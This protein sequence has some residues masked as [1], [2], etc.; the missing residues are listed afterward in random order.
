MSI[1]QERIRWKHWTFIVNETGRKNETERNRTKIKSTAMKRVFCEWTVRSRAQN[2]DWLRKSYT[3]AF[4]SFYYSL[5]MCAFHQSIRA[6]S[7]NH[8]PLNDSGNTFRRFR[9]VFF[10]CKRISLAVCRSQWIS[11]Q[12]A[13]A[14]ALMNADQLL[15]MIT[16]AKNKNE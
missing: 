13:C 1:N 15:V 4:W 16:R 8:L 3:P 6:P 12:M 10:T 2:F 5:L 9:W 11:S 14:S 7:S